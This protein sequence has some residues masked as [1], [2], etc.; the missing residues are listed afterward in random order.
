VILSGEKGVEVMV[1]LKACKHID[2][3]RTRRLGVFLIMLVSLRALIIGAIGIP[4][5]K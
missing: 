4:T 2:L 5:M 1:F 3:Q